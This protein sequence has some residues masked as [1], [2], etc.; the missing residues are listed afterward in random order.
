MAAAGARSKALGSS[1]PGWPPAS[2][3][4]EATVGPIA[5]WLLQPETAITA[6]QQVANLVARLRESNK[7]KLQRRGT[8]G[9]N[10]RK[11]LVNHH[12]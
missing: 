9:K 8:A 3:G 4:C 2:L 6:N 11:Y 7:A 1:E 5:P 12:G 10:A